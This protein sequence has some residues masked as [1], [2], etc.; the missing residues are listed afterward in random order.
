MIIKY[1]IQPKTKEQY[2]DVID[3]FSEFLETLGIDN[4]KCEV[5]DEGELPEDE[6]FGEDN[7]KR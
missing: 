1:S 5:G 4:W 2:R 7:I 6:G 3:Y